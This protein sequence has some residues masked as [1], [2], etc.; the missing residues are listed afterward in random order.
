M[1]DKIAVYAGSFDPV[2]KGHLHIIEEAY[3]LFDVVYVAIGVNPDKKY[4]FTVDERIELIKYHTDG[5]HIK[6]VPFNG[7]LVRFAQS[8]KAT[9]IVRG[10]RAAGDF[11][12]EFTLNGI[13]REI[14]P[15]IETVFFM[16]PNR[17]MFVSSSNVKELSKYGNDVSRFVPKNVENA[18]KNKIHGP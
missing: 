7:L 8:V 11:D 5:L 12:Y 16:A 6:V 10:L 4:M 13:N 2:T 14:A 17:F 15:E 3:K 9:H 1:R 18:L